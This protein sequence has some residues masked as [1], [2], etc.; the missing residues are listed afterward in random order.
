[1]EVYIEISNDDVEA[2]V[3]IE[4]VVVERKEGIRDYNLLDN[5]PMLNGKVIKGNMEEKDPTVPEWAKQEKK[6]E[7]QPEEIGAI[8][9][10][11]EM[12]LEDIIS[13]MNSVFN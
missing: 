11:D 5:L 9:V 4:N 6:P 13:M 12:T 7:Y 2:D 10:E 8:G 3:T 1:M